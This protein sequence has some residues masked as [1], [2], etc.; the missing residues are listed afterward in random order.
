MR[1]MLAVTLLNLRNLP[2]RWGSSFV[3]IIGIAGVVAVLISVLALATGFRRTIDNS[4]SEDR[5]IVLSRGAESEAGSGISRGA[6]AT[7]IDAPGIAR[8]RQGKAIASAEILVTAPVARK[9]D[10]RDA[11]VTLRGVGPMCEQLRPEVRLIAGRMFAPAV[12][13]IIVGRAAQSRFA[14]L[15]LGDRVL[16][17]GGEWT[18]VGV[19]ESGSNSHE[20]GLLADAETVLAAYQMKTFASLTVK[21]ASPSSFDTFKDALT[22]NPTLEVDVKREPEYVATVAKGLH[23]LLNM[24]AYTVG[25][26]MAVG[27][28]FA[29]LNT[30]YSAVR[31][32]ST[33]IATLRAVGFGTSAVVASVFVEALLLALVGATLGATIAH[34]LFNGHAISTIGGTAQGSQLVYQLTITPQAMGGAIALAMMV[35][36]LGSLFPAIRAARAPIATALRDS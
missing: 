18:V 2:Q 33:E 36:F 16:L 1:Q 32:R 31:A 13:E 22:T 12:H 20:S 25:G 11:Y 9:S 30:M 29:A 24:L 27:A 8:T 5:A 28:L 26:I 21:L 17:R 14:G 19:F 4:A 10:G 7:I 6:L 15:E 34:T 35:G 23:R 3:I